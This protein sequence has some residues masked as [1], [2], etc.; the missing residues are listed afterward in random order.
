MW[1]GLDGVSELDWEKP[2]ILQKNFYLTPH[3]SEQSPIKHFTTM[4][5]I[6]QYEK[7]MSDIYDKNL[8]AE[9]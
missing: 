7:V 5:N 4:D 6:H 3:I 2:Q 9:F 8:I 1:V